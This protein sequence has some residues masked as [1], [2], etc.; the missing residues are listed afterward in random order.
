M[1]SDIIH[2][3]E[4][5]S[6]RMTNPTT[7]QQQQQQHHQQLEYSSPSMQVFTSPSVRPSIKVASHSSLQIRSPPSSWISPPH[8]LTTPTKP[9]QNITHPAITLFPSA[10][11]HTGLKSSEAHSLKSS[12]DSQRAHGDSRKDQRARAGRRVLAGAGAGRGR[13]AGA[14]LG[15]SV[16]VGA[17][18]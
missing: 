12:E 1:V 5:S 3:H 9:P 14:G 10:A 13:G 15:A 4:R 6:K 8:H 18:G 11:R 16:G 7:K 2:D 17:G